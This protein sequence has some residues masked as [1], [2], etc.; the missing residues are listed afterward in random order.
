MNILFMNVNNSCK[1]I[2]MKEGKMLE[3]IG[4]LLEILAL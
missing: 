4:R 1:I 2:I 3:A